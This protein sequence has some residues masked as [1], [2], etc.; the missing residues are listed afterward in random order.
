VTKRPLP[1]F[2]KLLTGIA[3]TGLIAYAANMFESQRILSRLG[4]R[5]SLT[6]LANGVT[7]G[8]AGWRSDNGWTHRI[9][10]L[11]GTA[12]VATRARISQQLAAKPGIAGVEWR[13]R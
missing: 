3:A 12:D 4:Y 9:A 8:A 13:D 7:D 5:A 2:V 11:S 1:A 6:L 10:R